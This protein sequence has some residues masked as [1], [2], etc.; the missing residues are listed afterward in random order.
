MA[1]LKSLQNTTEHTAGTVFF[2]PLLRV[3]APRRLVEHYPHRCLSAAPSYRTTSTNGITHVR[4]HTEYYPSISLLRKYPEKSLPYNSFSSVIHKPSCLPSEAA[5]DP[6]ATH[7]YPVLL[8]LLLLLCLIIHHR[9]HNYLAK[10]GV[11]HGKDG[12]V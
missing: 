9:L 11:H 10:W 8:L 4:V 12:I 1:P 3:L 5:S 2:H 7:Y 6:D